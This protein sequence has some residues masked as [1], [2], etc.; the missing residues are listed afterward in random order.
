MKLRIKNKSI[1]KAPQSKNYLISSIKFMKE[2]KSRVLL[3]KTHWFI[4][5]S[6]AKNL[7]SNL[8]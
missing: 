3:I 1:G 4:N 2:P 5:H 7:S 8:T 6:T